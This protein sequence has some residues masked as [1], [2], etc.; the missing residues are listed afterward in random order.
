M[1]EIQFVGHNLWRIHTLNPNTG[2]KTIL[3]SPGPVGTLHRTPSS[4]PVAGDLELLV[5]LATVR[6]KELL[7]QPALISGALVVGKQH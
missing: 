7:G 3:W 2:M 1:F 6:V 4:V 5:E